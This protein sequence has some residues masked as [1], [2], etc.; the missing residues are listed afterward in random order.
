[1]L[2][3]FCCPECRKPLSID[4]CH[5]GWRIA[6]PTCEGELTVPLES[7]CA[8][9]RSNQPR[10]LR[11]AV[12]ACGLLAVIGLVALMPLA[13]H[14]PAPEAALAQAQPINRA[15]ETPQAPTVARSDKVPNAHEV[16]A[17]L[18]ADSEV[19]AAETEEAAETLGP[20]MPANPEPAT[21][22]F[23]ERAEDPAPRLPATQP[24]ES[25]ANPAAPAVKAPPPQPKK[26]PEEIVRERWASKR[27]SRLTDEELR[28]QLLLPPE[29]DLETVRGTIKKLISASGKAASTGQDV[30]PVFTARRTDLMGLPLLTGLLARKNQEEA[31]NLK[32]L[33]QHL[34]LHV[35]TSMP[36]LV[37]N[38]VDPR[39][40]PDILRHRLLDP[41]PQA[42]W[43]RPQAIATLRQ[44]LMPEHRNVRLILVDVLSKIEGRLAS[45]A[46]A[47]R[48]VFDLNPDVR[49]AALIALKSRPIAEYESA[50]IAGLRYP[51]P[52]LADH[53]A[54]ALVALDLRGAVPQLIPLLDARDLSEPYPVD[55][56]KTRRAV[57]PELVRVNHLRN[58]LL[59]HSYSASPADPVRGLAPNAEHLVPLP[60]SGARTPGKWGGGGSRG[61]VLTST[62][63]RADITFLRQ[64]F[65]VLQPV[66]N[67]G[68][69]WPEEQRYDYLVR[70]RPLS[71]EELLSWQEKVKDFRSAQPQRE[72]LLFALREL[73]GEDLG[74][75]PAAWKRYYSPITGRR[76]EKPLEPTEQLQHLRDCLVEGS[77]LQRAERVAALREKSGTEYDTALVS[78]LPQMTTELQKLGRTVL[79]DRFYCLPLK[80]LRAKLG[81]PD[82][83][84]RRAAV[85]V[86]KQ[87]K[88]KALVP[89][90]I[91]LLDDGNQDVAW[92]AHQLLQ[93]FS[94]RDLGPRP[95]A[96]RE[97]RQQAMT[98]WRD[99]W[100]QGNPK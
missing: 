89:E 92:Q 24:K 42:A 78:T 10:R 59:C 6:C 25:A 81:D 87:R 56:G 20:P 98:A 73:T 55:Q 85:S 16:R 71:P 14:G 45:M 40:D 100:G 67:H 62:F 7:S 97:Q 61:S 32:V 70:L 22:S 9:S 18:P 11:G 44:L 84:V 31:L 90:L 43:L 48:A 63:V 54:E 60:A 57:V 33:S 3:R 23:P 93:L 58:C 8:D 19:V 34:R 76:L 2:I 75:S 21:P 13:F 5:A 79:A 74:A 91:A 83:E 30:V 50:L 49:L 77:A 88:L 26:K 1:M 38:V 72:A 53:A 41:G 47:E 4:S 96:D 95:G 86:C 12:L 36:G 52:A 65:S 46:L 28:L 17:L 80:A 94:S 82:A 27:R 68:R 99:W 15:E 51:W 64:D 66:P 35:Q 39:P 29:V 37:D 69:L